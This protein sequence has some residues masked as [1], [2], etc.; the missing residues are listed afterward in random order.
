MFSMLLDYIYS[1]F[2]PCSQVWSLMVSQRSCMSHSY[3]LIFFLF[4]S[5]S[6]NTSIL[7]SSLDILNSL[8]RKRLST[9]FLYPTCWD[10]DFYNLNLL[11]F[12]NFW[13]FIIV[14]LFYSAFH[15]NSLEIIY[16]STCVLFKFI[17][18]SHDHFLFLC[19]MY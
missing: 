13:I 15:S 2:S 11:L 3:F 19:L 5:I 1:P 16:V 6:S 10:F 7:S 8:Y 14:F 17:D 18:H 4:L 9:V 12:Q